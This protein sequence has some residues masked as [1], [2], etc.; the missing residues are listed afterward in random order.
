MNINSLYPYTM[1]TLGMPI[2]K[3]I[4]F[5]GNIED[6]WIAENTSGAV[7]EHEYV[8]F[9]TWTLPYTNQGFCLV[10]T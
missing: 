8:Y 7:I 1:G 9:F 4:A 2:G 10:T 3:P 5:E 6:C